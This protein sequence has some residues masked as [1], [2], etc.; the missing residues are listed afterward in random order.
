[1][2]DVNNYLSE[3]KDDD[4]I[5]F[6]LETKGGTKQH[7][8]SIDEIIVPQYIHYIDDQ[9]VEDNYV[10]TYS[11]RDNSFLGWTIDIEQDGQ[12]HP[13]VYFELD[14]SY[15]IKSFKLYKKTLLFC[16]LRNNDFRK[17][18]FDTKSTIMASIK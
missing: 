15:D 11:K 6:S 12:Q 17:Y 1:A 14:Q 2:I 10:V 5:G 4:I 16:Y 13:D 3:T 7:M 18:L 9:Y 8:E